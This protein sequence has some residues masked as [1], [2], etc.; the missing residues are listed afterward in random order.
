MSKIFGP[1]TLR[2][3][4]YAE[5]NPSYSDYL[6][7][8]L[9]EEGLVERINDDEDRRVVFV[10]PTNEGAALVQ[11]MKEEFAAR[12]REIMDYLG[13]KDGKELIRITR[14]VRAFLESQPENADGGGPS[15]GD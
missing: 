2:I 13:E 11:R 6:V 4:R 8:S 3:G 12:I 7:N 1:A 15:C 9:E 14:K 5:A 10:R